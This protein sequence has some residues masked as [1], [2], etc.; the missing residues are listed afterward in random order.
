MQIEGQR[1]VEMREARVGR[2]TRQKMAR[3]LRVCRALQVQ[4]CPGRL[5]LL[6][7]RLKET[8]MREKNRWLKMKGYLRLA[9]AVEGE[10]KDA[11]GGPH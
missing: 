11:M 7:A 9:Q 8:G 6:V 2:R 3:H 1:W 5:M 4:G 10:L